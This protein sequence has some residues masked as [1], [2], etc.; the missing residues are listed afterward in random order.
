MKSHKS[1]N[2]KKHKR[3]GH[4][5]SLTESSVKKPQGRGN[6][7]YSPPLARNRIRGLGINI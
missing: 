2:I 4:Q 5:P 3:C 6:F 1:K 7:T